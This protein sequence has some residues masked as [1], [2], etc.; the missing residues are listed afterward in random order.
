V[1]AGEVPMAITKCKPIERTGRVPV[2]TTQMN[3]NISMPS[4]AESSD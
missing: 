4:K 2:M 1:G 3:L